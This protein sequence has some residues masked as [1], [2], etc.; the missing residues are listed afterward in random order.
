M[1]ESTAYQLLFQN[2]LSARQ[3]TESCSRR[4]SLSLNRAFIEGVHSKFH[5]MSY[6]AFTKRMTFLYTFEL[7]HYIALIVATASMMVYLYS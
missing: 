5:K 1:Q 3:D 2:S 4:Q 7:V 6:L